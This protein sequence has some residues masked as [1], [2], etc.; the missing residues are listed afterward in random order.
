MPR[1]VVAG[2]NRALRRAEAFQD[3]LWTLFR[4]PAA[5]LGAVRDE[6]VVCRCEGVSAGA[7]RAAL[8]AHGADA[9]TAKRLT[10]IGM[11]RCGGRTCAGLLARLVGRPAAARRSPT[12]SSRPAPP[13]SRRRSRASP[14]RSP[15]GAGIAAR[16][17]RPSSRVPPASGGTGAGAGPTSWSIGAGIVG[18]CVAREL[19]RAGEEVLVVDRDA[20]GQQASTANAG[21]LHVQL[22]SFDFGAKAEAGGGP[23]AETLKLGPPAVALWREIAEESGEDL[24]LRITGGLM[25]AESERDWRFLEEKTALEARHGVETHLLRG[26][27]LRNL[28]PHLSTDLIGAAFCPAEGKINPLTATFAVVDQARRAGAAFEPDAPVLAIERAS[29][30]FEVATAAGRVSA[31]RI[32]NC[33]GAWS[34]RIGAMVGKPI[35]V[36]GAPL[37]MMVTEPGPPVLSRLLAHADRHLS[38]KQTAAGS[39]LIGGGWSA[40]PRRGDG[41]EQGPALGDRGQRLG[42]LPRA[43]AGRRLSPPAGVGRHEHRHRRRPDPGRDAGRPRLLQLR[44]L[45]RVHA[46]AGSGPPDHGGHARQF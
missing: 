38:L 41:G 16:P 3:A 44:H 28:E 8:A 29:D 21:S 31:R 32:V 11:G 27:E 36:S 19:A 13:S 37:Q 24:E 22:L 5:D 39:L 34:S 45:Q 17:L 4:A 10:R 18:A 15:S 35:P 23:A 46:R 6:T 42:R 30:G 7:V 33:A 20:V 40:R 2:A 12:P 1:S 14:S 26:N 25:V 43:A 9:G